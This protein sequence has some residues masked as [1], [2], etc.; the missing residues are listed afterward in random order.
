MR[1]TAA[2][3]GALVVATAAYFVGSVLLA[4]TALGTANFNDCAAFLPKSCAQVAFARRIEKAESFEAKRALLISLDTAY[5]DLDTFQPHVS[6]A[7]RSDPRFLKYACELFLKRKLQPYESDVVFV[8]GG[9][10]HL[11][12]DDDVAL[13]LLMCFRAEI[14]CYMIEPRR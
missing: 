9:K 4:Y 3:G 8:L 7:L 13:A 10:E 2:L 14:S 5:S 11:D 6:V 1:R 12:P